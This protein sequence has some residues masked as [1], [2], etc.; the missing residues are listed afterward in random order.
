M[1][2]GSPPDAVHGGL[3]TCVV[4]IS[5]RCRCRREP[6]H[7]GCAAAAAADAEFRHVGCLLRVCRYPPARPRGQIREHHPPPGGECRHQHRGR[8][9]VP[10]HA[11][12]ADPGH[13]SDRRIG[14]AQ[15]DHAD[16]GREERWRVADQAGRDRRTWVDDAAAEE[17]RNEQRQSPAGGIVVQQQRRPLVQGDKLDVGHPGALRL[18]RELLPRGA[19]QPSPQVGLAIAGRLSSSSSH[20]VSLP[21]TRIPGH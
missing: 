17:I 16:R 14:P 19:R 10:P 4:M 5:R 3:R 20:H 2:P 9:R 15:L 13:G 6:T 12:S 7:F 1:T 8:R 21:I 18:L 11:G